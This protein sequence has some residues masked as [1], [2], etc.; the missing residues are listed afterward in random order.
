MKIRSSL[1]SDSILSAVATADVDPAK[2]K[3]AL[4]RLLRAIL[5]F[6]SFFK[7]LL[8]RYRPQDFRML[9]EDVWKLDEQEYT[10]SFS[11][12]ETEDD[13]RASSRGKRKEA[14]LKPIGDLGY[15]G[16]T[17]FTTANSKYLIK[18]LPRR[19]EHQFFTHDLLG[20]Y[21]S[22]MKDTPHSLLIAT[23]RRNPTA[24]HKRRNTSTPSIHEPSGSRPRILSIRPACVTP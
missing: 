13:N 24:P 5:A 9:R 14:Q 23:S 6:F 19:F 3:N 10:A 21:I 11:T 17:F 7:L 22:H 15:S 1:I 4:R 16:S 2:R 8:A 20:P 18:S 12:G